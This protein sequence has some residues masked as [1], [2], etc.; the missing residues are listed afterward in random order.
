MALTIDDIYDKEFA[1]K[2]GGYD[3]DDVDQFL[4]EICDEMTN[5]QER[6]A[7]LE[8]ELAKAQ[9]ELRAAK[10]AVQPI[11][12][13]VV[14]QPVETAPPVVVKTSETLES[15]LLNAQKLSDEALENAQR[16]ADNLVKQAEEKASKLVD[17][18][19]EE[20]ETLE[21]SLASMKD[22]ARTYRKDFLDLLKKY[23]G[24]MEED[25]ELMDIK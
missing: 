21:K 4:D 7:S 5:M 13:P 18:A 17:D 22:A 19:Q 3:R 9:T 12:A 6:T 14:A 20:K 10:E 24:L 8:Q 15:I 11:A 1:L 2:G 25:S 16:K 23:Q